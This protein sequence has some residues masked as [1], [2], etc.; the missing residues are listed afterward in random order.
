MESCNIKNVVFDIGNV[1]VRWSP[2]EITRLTFGITAQP[3]QMAQFVF[4]S[5][6]WAQL[7]KGELSEPEAKMKLRDEFGFSADC[8]EKLFYYVKHTQLLLFG[9]VELLKRIKT[10]GYHVYALTDNVTEIVD[11]LKSQYDFWLLFDGATVSADVGCLKPQPEI[12]N[13]LMH[14]HDIV[15]TES[16]FIDDM[17]HNIEGAQSLGFSAV[18]FE[19][20]VQCERELKLLGLSF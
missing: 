13:H 16:V 9:S 12:F 2:I 4:Q 7:N 10:A 20:A 5:D 8:T 18:Q 14:E 11:Y 1:I 19:N 17:L 6:L 3:K 15:A